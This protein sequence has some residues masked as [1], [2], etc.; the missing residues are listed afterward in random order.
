MRNYTGSKRVRNAAESARL[1]DQGVDRILKRHARHIERRELK[2]DTRRQVDSFFEEQIE[3][4][5][6]L[7]EMLSD[8]FED[9]YSDSNYYEDGRWTH[10]DALYEYEDFGC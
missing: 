5:V 4:A 9:D 1:D 10:D 8:I 2:A 3:A 7:E 6:E